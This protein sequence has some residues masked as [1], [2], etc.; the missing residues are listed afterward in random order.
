LCLQCSLH[1]TII[2]KTA[3]CTRGNGLK[4]RKIASSTATEVAWLPRAKA[5]QSVKPFVDLAFPSVATTS[6]ELS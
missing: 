1:A 5:R 2:D 4:P 6:T 3:H